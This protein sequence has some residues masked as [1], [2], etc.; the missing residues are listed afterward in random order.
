MN[1]FTVRDPAFRD[2]VRESF[3]SQTFMRTLG[4]RMTGLEPGRCILEMETRPDLC[5]QNGFVHAG[6]TTAIA[7]T[8]A[9]YAA[10]SL[11]P[12][13]ANIL[14]VEFKMNLLNPAAGERLTARAEVIKSGRTL[15]VVRS[16]VVA[17]KD[18][19]ESPVATMLA[20]MMS[21]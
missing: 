11:V 15:M 2:R 1:G 17:L 14:T 8:A 4:V 3:D 5:Q 7:D 13:G 21:L 9:G 20:T 10:F 19:G 18:G 12:P 6:A 16:D